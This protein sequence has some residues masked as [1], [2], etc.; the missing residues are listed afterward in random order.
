MRFAS[1]VFFYILFSVRFS[2]PVTYRQYPRRTQYS[3]L[4]FRRASSVKHLLSTFIFISNAFAF[5]HVQ[6]HLLFV[7]FPGKFIF[8]ICILMTFYYN[9]LSSMFVYIVLKQSVLLQILK[10]HI[11]AGREGIP[12]PPPRRLTRLYIYYIRSILVYFDGIF[13][14]FPRYQKR[15]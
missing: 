1:S 3:K 4:V 12:C 15:S 14:Y 6:S 2:P 7:A 11:L 5:L 10:M 8:H 13:S 9:C